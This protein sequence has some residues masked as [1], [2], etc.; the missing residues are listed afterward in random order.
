MCVIILQ[1]SASNIQGLI[2]DFDELKYV[3][4]NNDTESFESN[5]NKLK[6]NAN[7]TKAMMSFFVKSCAY[8]S[9]FYRG[10]DFYNKILDDI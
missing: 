3:I 7:K 5:R 6:L 1:L 10:I 4:K 8:N 9:I 2:N